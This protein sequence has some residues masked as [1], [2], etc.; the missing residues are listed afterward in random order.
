[1]VNGFTAGD[2][3]KRIDGTPFPDGKALAVVR[4]PVNGESG[5]RYNA[6]YIEGGQWV[7]WIE[8]RVA[9]AR[10]LM[11]LALSA[12]GLQ[13]EANESVKILQLKERLEGELQRRRRAEAKA[14][15][16]ND[17]IEPMRQREAAAIRKLHAFERSMAIEHLRSLRHGIALNKLQLIKDIINDEYFEER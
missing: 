4:S 12:G 1:M 9:S 6:V 11:E 16:A 15:K 13:Q 2:I 17:Q 5:S 3:I 7:P 10:D 14:A 8:V